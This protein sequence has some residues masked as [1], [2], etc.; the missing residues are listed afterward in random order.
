MNMPTSNMADLASHQAVSPSAAYDHADRRTVISGIGLVTPIADDLGKL[1]DFVETGKNGFAPIDRFDTAWCET[2]LACSY[3]AASDIT[4][5]SASFRRKWMDRAA[6]YVLDALDRSLAQSGIDLTRYAKERIAVVIGTS[7]SGLVSTEEIYAAELAGTLEQSDPRRIISILSSH[8]SAVVA[9]ALQA[10]GIRRTTSSACASSTG[11]MGVASDLIHHGEADVVITGGSDTVSLAV[12]AGFNSLRALAP[13]G[14]QPFSS[15]PGISLG[16][17][18]A[19][20]VLER[21][22]HALDRG[23]AIRAEIIGY[24]LSGD[25][26]HA[27]APD[28]DGDGIRRVLLSALAD[29]QVAAE[30]V[31]YLSAHGTGTD[32]ND[33]AE[34][35][36]SAAVFGKNAVLSSS[37]SIFGHT[38]GAS[39][40]IETALVIGMA[41]R[42]L[43]P[44]TLAFDTVRKGCVDLDY[45]PNSARLA[46]TDV[47][48]CNNYGFGGSNA[49]VVLKRQPA[50]AASGQAVPHAGHRVVISGLGFL[51]GNF[52]AGEAGLLEALTSKRNRPEAQSLVVDA[53]LPDQFKRQ[54]GRASPIIKFAVSA[55]G[56]A[57]TSANVG[58]ADAAETGL[59]FSAITGAQRSTEKYMESVFVHGPTLAS[60]QYFA[61]TTNNAPGGQVSICFG[62][63][64]YNTTLCGPAGALGYSISLVRHGR[65]A[66]V[67]TG[68]ADEHSDALGR[69][70]S[71]AAVTSPDQ[72]QAFDAQTG[73]NFCEGAVSVVF[74]TLQAAQARGHVALAEITGFAE[75]QD[76]T[77]SGVKRNGDALVRAI[78]SA[79]LQAGIVASDIDA[80]IAHGAGPSYFPA[81]EAAALKRVFGPG[82]VQ[83]L[84]LASALGTGPSHSPIAGVAAAAALVRQNPAMLSSDFS[85]SAKV[86]SKRVLAV[87]IDLTGVS[88]AAIVERLEDAP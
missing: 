14:C 72:V 80:I 1:C 23:A 84:S 53:R 15:K 24:A 6:W 69:C 67:V 5:G 62:L 36:A 88:C 41:E 3:P 43:I 64:G 57:L 20:F 81:A 2:N 39:G 44:P 28:E 7:H 19:V 18:A 63:K 11:A 65:Q 27:T 35:R 32:A 37:K 82:T 54:V 30:D 61:H 73:I 25:A 22:D 31:D 75:F 71:H 87:S 8:I 38:L 55:T 29:A 78:T 59:I 4:F 77:Y 79:M 46:K 33:L 56:E 83:I 70:L 51:N 47:F 86:P 68:G 45:V 52:P 16:E 60:A 42:G 50:Y 12:M 66:R 26:H 21:L 17:G 49:S 34:S 48:V 40:V 76:G 10:K 13:D 58:H 9:A 85:R 74:E